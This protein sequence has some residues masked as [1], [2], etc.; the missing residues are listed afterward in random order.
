MLVCKEDQVLTRS[1]VDNIDL[2]G[3]FID[4]VFDLFSCLMKYLGVIIDEGLT[5]K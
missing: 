3:D 4:R 1:E 5:V 2:D